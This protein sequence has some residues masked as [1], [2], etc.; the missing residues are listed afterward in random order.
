MCG[1][2]IHD[3]MV[4]GLPPFDYGRER[5]PCPACDAEWRAEQRK[6]KA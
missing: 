2:P 5:W 1:L 6:K 3:P 4:C